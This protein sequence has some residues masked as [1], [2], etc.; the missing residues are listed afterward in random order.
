MD[1]SRQAWQQKYEALRIEEA[2]SYEKLRQESARMH[3][4]LVDLLTALGPNSQS[5]NSPLMI[6]EDQQVAYSKY[7][8]SNPEMQQNIRGKEVRIPVSIEQKHQPQY[9]PYTGLSFPEFN[10]EGPEIWVE[11]CEQYFDRY[12]VPEQQ[13]IG[14]ASMHIEGDAR[15]WK[16]AYFFNRPRVNW[17]E[18]S[19]A[20]CKRFTAAK[21][22]YPI[23]EF[24]T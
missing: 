23:R 8:S 21:E 10:G 22:G 20:I 12:Q 18:F 5:V 11:A 2:T 19:D 13:W 9:M 17:S 4:Q 6:R 24:S 3:Q 15:F 1:G 14:I 7:S 16:Q